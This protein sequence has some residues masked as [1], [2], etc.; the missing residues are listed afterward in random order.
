M[1]V[2]IKTQPHRTTFHQNVATWCSIFYHIC[3][4]FY[5]NAHDLPSD[6]NGR[7]FH[8]IRKNVV[9]VISLYIEHSPRLSVPIE[10]RIID[11]IIGR[12]APKKKHTIL[13]SLRS[14]RLGYTAHNL[15]LIAWDQE[16][17]DYYKILKRINRDLVASV[18]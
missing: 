2:L 14:Y 4:L 3:I 8:L 1:G 11:N 18:V 7:H 13:I 5:K 17:K 10:R 16:F 15:G 12:A 6:G 9:I